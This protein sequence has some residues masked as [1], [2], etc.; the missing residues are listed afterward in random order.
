[1]RTTPPAALAAL[2][3]VALL[4]GCSH[5]G[6]DMRAPSPDQ[7]QSIIT[8]TAPV[9]TLPAFDDIGD[10]IDLGSLPVDSGPADSGDQGRP[11]PSDLAV[12]GFS[13]A[14]PWPDGGAIPKR[15]TCDGEDVSPEMSWTEP[16]EGTV[17]LAIVVV[18]PDA[19]DFV[20]WIVAGIP[21]D[22]TTVS[23]DDPLFTPSGGAI[24][25][26][27]DFGDPGWGGPCPPDGSAHDYRF[28]VHAL[29]QQ[30]EMPSGTPGQELL[31]VIDFATLYAAIGSG[32][33]G[34]G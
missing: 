4:A 33:Y 28:E 34:A 15:Y 18:D 31:R 20:H 8:T 12:T 23:A 26:I 17:E 27:N 13:L 14:L 1:M 22:V 29:S 21:P 25:G 30:T 3:S 32:T 2:V 5:D 7:T 11:D 24:V 6:R 10:T 19:D 16:P 9:D